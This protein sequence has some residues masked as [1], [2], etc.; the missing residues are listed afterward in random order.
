MWNPSVLSLN[1]PIHIEPGRRKRHDAHVH[2]GPP[3]VCRS[4]D[5]VALALF[6]DHARCVVAEFLGQAGKDPGTLNNM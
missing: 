5:A 6:A 4:D 2:G 1:R 3:F